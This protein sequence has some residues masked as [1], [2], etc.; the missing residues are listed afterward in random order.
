MSDRIRPRPCVDHRTVLEQIKFT[1]QC[2]AA[3]GG[4]RVIPGS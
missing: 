2:V 3:Q 1:R 4:T